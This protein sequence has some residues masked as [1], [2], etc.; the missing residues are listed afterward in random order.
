GWV[1]GGLPSLRGRVG[2]ARDGERVAVAPDGGPVVIA[3]SPADKLRE[4]EIVCHDAKVLRVDARDDTLIAAYLIEPG[5]ATYELDDL[6]GEYGVELVP[7]P[8]TDEETAALVRR[9]AV[10]P[11]L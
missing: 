10:P 3:S 9:A 4:A 8:P 11:R 7:Q 1:E 6:A 2:F 5:R